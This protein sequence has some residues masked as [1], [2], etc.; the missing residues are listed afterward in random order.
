MAGD[1]VHAVRRGLALL[2]MACGGMAGPVAPPREVPILL[3]YENGVAVDPVRDAGQVRT[4]DAGASP[5]DAGIAD[6]GAPIYVNPPFHVPPHDG[7][8][9]GMSCAWLDAPPAVNCWKAA[10]E[11]VHTCLGDA[12]PGR[13]VDGYHAE[14]ASGGKLQSS[15][16][17]AFHPMDGGTHGWNTAVRVTTASGAVC[18]ET[19]NGFA[20]AR[21]TTP[22]GTVHFRNT[23]LFEYELT[24][25]DG[26]VYTNVS[27]AGTCDSFGLRFLFGGVPGFDA[28]CSD[29]SCWQRATGTVTGVKQLATCTR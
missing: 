21:V 2:T 29:T 23:S 27:D 10:M 25:P 1:P 15:A 11:S 6:A 26:R 13:F 20:K 24:C 12:G 18:L 19:A 17:A 14:L 5:A 9:L 7:G 8:V 22:G 4:T 3:P 16:A 28:Q